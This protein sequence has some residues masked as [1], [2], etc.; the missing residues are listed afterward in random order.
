MRRGNSSDFKYCSS[1]CVR[2]SFK[3]LLSIVRNCSKRMIE[4][5]GSPSI[6]PK[7]KCVGNFFFL[8]TRLVMA[9]IMTVGLCLFPI[10]LEITSTGRVPPCSEP[11]TGFKSAYLL[12]FPNPVFLSLPPSGGVAVLASFGRSWH[13]HIQFGLLF[14]FQGTV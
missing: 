5:A 13:S 9:A 1:R 8:R 7:Y 11:T 3:R 4:F 14:N 2:C 12:C 10:S 6:C